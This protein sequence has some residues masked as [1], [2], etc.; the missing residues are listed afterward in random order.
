MK[1]QQFWGKLII[2][3][4]NTETIKRQGFTGMLGRLT[5]RKYKE[6]VI[7]RKVYLNV[8]ESLILYSRG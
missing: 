4:N 2:P 3:R 6:R 5:R 7:M 8:H 1:R